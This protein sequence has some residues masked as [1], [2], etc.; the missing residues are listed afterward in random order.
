MN[1]NDD[2]YS[3]FFVPFIAPSLNEILNKYF[4]IYNVK[5][6]IYIDRTTKFK[7]IYK[8]EIF[9]IIE[10]KEIKEIQEQVFIAY[11][12]ILGNKKQDEKDGMIKKAYDVDNYVYC[13]KCITDAIKN[14]NIIKDD[15]NA[16]VKSIYINEAN[17]ER[18]IEKSGIIVIIEKVREDN[19]PDLKK[20]EKIKYL[21]MKKLIKDQ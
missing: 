21:L 4:K 10:N 14:N 8:K 5:N 16:N 19:F 18:N 17:K 9:K 3:F 12:P 13:C 11:Y 20:H 7:D 2:D 1:N 6:K 15:N